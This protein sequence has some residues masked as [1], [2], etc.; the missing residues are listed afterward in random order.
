MPFDSKDF[1]AAPVCAEIALL[2]KMSEIL[3]VP[4]RWC[5][6][7]AVS[8]DGSAFCIVGAASNAHTHIAWCPPYPLINLVLYALNQEVGYP[9]SM[10]NDAPATTHADV[11]ALLSRVRKSYE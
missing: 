1:V 9:V 6:G 3:A 4:E 10:F 2:D 11:V 5:K 8:P 7:A